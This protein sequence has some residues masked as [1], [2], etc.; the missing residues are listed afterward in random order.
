MISPLQLSVLKHQ[1]SE[2][3]RFLITCLAAYGCTF[4]LA[5][6]IP[7]S[8]DLTTSS[9]ANPNITL[10]PSLPSNLTLSTDTTLS[11]SSKSQ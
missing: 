8:F 4:A 1:I 2:M 9:R 7:L 10:P 3:H 5:A 11:T 6:S